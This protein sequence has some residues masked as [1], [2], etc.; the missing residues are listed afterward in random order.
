[1][2]FPKLPAGAISES[3]Y[4]IISINSPY[5]LADYVQKYPEKLG[6]TINFA[7]PLDDEFDLALKYDLETEGQRWYQP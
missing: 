1:M 3:L 4:K 7:F 6:E 2:L 5:L